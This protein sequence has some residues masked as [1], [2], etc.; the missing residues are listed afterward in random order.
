MHLKKAFLL[1]FLLTAACGANAAAPTAT[2][3]PTPAATPTPDWMLEGWNLVWQDEFDGE[4][5]D[6]DNWTHEVGGHGWG[7]GEAQYYSDD[8]KNSYIEDGV[9]V[10]Q[11]L[12][13]N[14]SGKL[15]TSARLSTQGKVE[16]AY[17]R[18][19]A[20]IQIP[21]GQSLWPAFWMLG[22]DIDQVGWPFCG[23]ID[24]M[25]NIGSE[26]SVIH[27]TV[28]GPRYF[29]ANGV[30]MAK[31]LSGGAQYTDEFHIFAIEWEEDEIRWYMDGQMYQKLTP[32]AVPGD[33]VFNHPFF[34]IV[35]LAVGGE[36]PGY[37]DGTTTFPQIMKI[38]YVRI[39]EKADAVE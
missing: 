28:H 1:L 15:Y 12:Q 29:G 31:R 8:P 36:W 2:E 23:E 5:I 11:A 19:E 24:I 9:L 39:Y 7:N 4:T 32:A 26:P 34:I 21:V 6:S 10:I 20:R 37:P 33:W 13:E 22:N 18:I 17:G 35:N 16:V 38:D 27:G 25:E 30:G 14:V 3:P